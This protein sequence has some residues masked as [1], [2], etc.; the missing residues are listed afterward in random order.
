M[1]KQLDRRLSKLETKI[2]NAAK[3]KQANLVIVKRIIVNPDGTE[4][5]VLRRETACHSQSRHLA[6]ESHHHVPSARDNVRTSAI[7]RRQH[8]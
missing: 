2:E 1:S 7:P 6:S 5:G 3:P 8:P 4:S